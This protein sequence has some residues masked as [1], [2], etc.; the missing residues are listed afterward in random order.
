VW[1]GGV[2]PERE[3][4]LDRRRAKCSLTGDGS[5]ED[6]PARSLIDLDKEVV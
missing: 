1:S 4:Y 2:T 3:V 5:G 6:H